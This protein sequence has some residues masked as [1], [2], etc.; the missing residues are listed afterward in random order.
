M[1]KQSLL[2]RES[3]LCLKAKGVMRPAVLPLQE[4]GGFDMAGM[5]QIYC[6]D[7]KGKTTAAIEQALRCAGSG[8]N[9]LIMQLMKPED[10]SERM[11]L[12]QCDNITLWDAFP[13]AKFSFQMTTR[14]RQKAAL[15]YTDQFRKMTEIVQHGYQMLVLDEL[16]SCVTC[17]LFRHR[18]RFPF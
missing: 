2:C 3:V 10:S 17:A 7:G 6:G 12:R 14:E 1:T 5:I 18:F 11:M 9:V 15:W 13:D 4:Q 8:K 16:T